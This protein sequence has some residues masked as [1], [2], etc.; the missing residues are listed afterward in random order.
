MQ[1]RSRTTAVPLPRA[2]SQCARMAFARTSGK[3]T[4][5]CGRA[6]SASGGGDSSRLMWSGMACKHATSVG[7]WVC[8]CWFVW[9]VVACV[10]VVN[11]AT[12]LLL[13]V[14]ACICLLLMRL[15]WQGNLF[16][17]GSSHLG[18]SGGCGK[19]VPGPCCGV[20]VGCNRVDR[21]FA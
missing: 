6:S 2:S 9:C 15:A 1:S 13:S 14:L 18:W 12:I 20:D 8:G 10:A 5:W 4:C 19:L 3:W 7:V 16:N 17:P 11:G 21:S